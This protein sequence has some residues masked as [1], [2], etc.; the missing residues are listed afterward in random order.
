MYQRLISGILIVI[1]SLFLNIG[2]AYAHPIDNTDSYFYFENEV[3]GYEIPKNEVRLYSYINWAQAALLVEKNFDIVES[4]IFK[5]LEYQDTY[6]KYVSNQISVL[7]NDELCEIQVDDSPVTEEQISLSLGT[8]VIATFVCPSEIQ[9]VRISNTLFIEDFPYES[10]YVHVY[11]GERLLHSLTLD[12]ETSVYAFNLSSLKENPLG[13]ETKDN[14]ANMSATEV[15][16]DEAALGVQSN[17]Q[18]RSNSNPKQISFLQKISDTI[19]LQ[20]NAIKDQSLPILLVLVFLLGFL[21][22]VEAGHSKAILASSLVHKKMSLKQGLA[23]AA[24]FTVTHLGDIIIVGL[25][26]LAIDNYFDV[27]SNLTMIERFAGFALFFMSI[28]LFLKSTHVYIENWLVNKGALKQTDNSGH[29]EHTHDHGHDH[30]HSHSHEIDTVTSLKEQLFLGFLAGLA[31]CV[32]GWTIF[33]LILSTNKIWV[34]VPATLAFGL[35]IFVA[36]ALVVFVIS[37]LKKR[38]YRKFEKFA[39]ISPIVSAV[40]LLIYSIFLIT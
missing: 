37:H 8:R 24:I 25:V 5:L 1:A 15:T 31:P 17:E 36:L 28:Y 27:F 14:S 6:N 33:M 32:F 23:Y 38:A 2:F 3:D 7:N 35:G 11:S 18:T 40:F 34:L 12:K 26:F 21:H 16:S 39:E 20:T 10:N 9:D 30:D 19:F 22:T 13:D 29:H 4:D